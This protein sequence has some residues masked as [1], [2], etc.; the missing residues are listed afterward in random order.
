MFA[1][2]LL[3]NNLSLRLKSILNIGKTAKNPNQYSNQYPNQKLVFNV[4]K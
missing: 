2:R 3:Y 4:H 1:L